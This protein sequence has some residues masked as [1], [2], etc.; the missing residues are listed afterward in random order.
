MSD[1]QGQPESTEP[2]LPE[3]VTSELKRMFRPSIE[4]SEAVDKAVMADAQNILAPET[5]APGVRVSPHRPAPGMG[6]W[7]FGLV[8]A[9]SLAAVLV[10]V[11]LPNNPQPNGVAE[12]AQSVEAMNST[13]EYVAKRDIDGNGRVDILDAYTLSRMIEDSTA[14]ISKDQ[15]ND[16]ILDD[17]DVNLVAETAVTL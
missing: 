14:G 4:I 16:N 11:M 9:G 7:A 13:P 8:A 3:E 15:N 12:N 17:N 10:L 6:R 5:L 1:D 2:D